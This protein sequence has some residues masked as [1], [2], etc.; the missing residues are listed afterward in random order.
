ML[1]TTPKLPQP[2]INNLPTLIYEP[3]SHPYVQELLQM[4]LT[5]ALHSTITDPIRPAAAFC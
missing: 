5:A 1:L 4:W 2:S 3:Y